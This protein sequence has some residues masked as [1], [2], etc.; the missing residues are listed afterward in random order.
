MAK[1]KKIEQIFQ[2]LEAGKAEKSS[3]ADSPS[4]IYHSPDEYQ[5]TIPSLDAW[6]YGERAVI[7]FQQDNTPV[8]SIVFYKEGHAIPDVDVSEDGYIHMH[9]PFNMFDS[10]VDILRY[11]KPVKFDFNVLEEMAFFSTEWEPVGEGE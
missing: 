5:I 1:R 9:L 10:V 11:E 3:S 7:R 2:K 4:Y 8:G 6:G